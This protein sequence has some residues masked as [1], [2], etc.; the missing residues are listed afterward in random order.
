MHII[1]PDGTVLR[2]GY[3]TLVVLREVGWWWMA[4]FMWPPLLWLVELGYQI[5]AR[6]RILFSKVI[7]RDE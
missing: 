3:G 6:N 2:A 5:I 4:P 1:M 7:F